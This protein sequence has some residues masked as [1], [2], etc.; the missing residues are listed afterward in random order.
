[1][2]EAAFYAAVPLP[3]LAPVTTSIPKAWRESISTPTPP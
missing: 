1:M 3:S 2:Q